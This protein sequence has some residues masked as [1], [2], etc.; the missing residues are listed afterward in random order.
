M[1][2]GWAEGNTHTINEKLTA[3]YTAINVKDNLCYLCE[4][5]MNCH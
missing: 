4:K 3:N 5:N 1:S 2:P